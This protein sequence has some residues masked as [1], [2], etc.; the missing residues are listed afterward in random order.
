MRARERVAT[1]GA[2]SSSTGSLRTVS[3]RTRTVLSVLALL[4]VLLVA[5]CVIVQLVLGERLRAQ[6]EDRLHDRASAAAAL[7]GTVSNDDLA[8]RLSAQGVS[9]VI[10]SPDGGSVVA[11]P[12]PEQLREGPGPGGPGLLGG[13]EVSNAPGTASNSDESEGEEA[14]DDSAGT[15]SAAAGAAVGIT[16][17]SII[18]SDWQIVTLESDLS[19]GSVLTLTVDA[20][21]VEQTLE[22]LRWIMVAA[23][24]GVLLLAAAALVLVVR[25]SLRP[26]ESMTALARDIAAGDRGR[27]LRPTRSRTEIGRVAVAFD[28]MLDAVEGAERAARAAESTALEAETAAVRSEQL[29]REAEARVRAFVSDAAHELRTPVAGM[30]AAADTL[31][32]ASVD[33]DE[34]ERLAS[35]VVREAGRASRLIDDMLLMARVD[36][37]LE[38]DSRPVDLVDVVSLEAERQRIRRPG[39]EL[40]LDLPAVPTVVHGDP[41]RLSQVVANLLDNAARMSGDGAVTVEVSRVGSVARVVVSDDGPGVP[42]SD[43]ERIFDRLVRLDSSRNSGGGGAGLGLPIA[44]GIARAHGGELVCVDPTDAASAAP[45]AAFVIT[46]PVP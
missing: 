29:A 4:A 22:Q 23:S 31:V 37:G 43:R 42:S 19:D 40:V 33:R 21:G 18:A 11:G 1:P 7:I 39:L 10:R 9:V 35:H 16:S 24:G 38:L 5:L 30:Q 12:T 25:G 13:P 45:G 32:R 41:E 44:R 17:S 28:E 8:E 27:R 36:R 6:I 2:G 15:R 34:R 20:S 14:G 3:L 26:L 46:L